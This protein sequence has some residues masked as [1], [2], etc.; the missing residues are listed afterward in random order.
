[1]AYLGQGICKSIRHAA[2]AQ[3]CR[4]IKAVKIEEGEH[5]VR[6]VSEA[7]VLAVLDGFKRRQEERIRP[8]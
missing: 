3:I 7:D 8:T 4:N 6:F 1:V 5:L 2:K